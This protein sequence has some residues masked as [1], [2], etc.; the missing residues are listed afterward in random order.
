MF[1]GKGA[2]E[3][4]DDFRRIKALPIRKG[5]PEGLVDFMSKLLRVPGS[6]ATLREVQARALYELAMTK[7]AFLPIRIGGGKSLV[8]LLAA[9]VLE[10]KRPLLIVPAKLVEKTERERKSYGKDW[11]V[12]K[13]LKI[14]SYELLGRVSGA[15]MIALYNPD[16]IIVDECFAAGTGI[17]TETGIRPI[18]SIRPGDRVWCLSS[19]GWLLRDVL[20]TYESESRDIYH[21][22]IDTRVYTCTGGHPFCT[23]RGWVNARDLQEGDAILSDMRTGFPDICMQKAGVLQ[24]KMQVYPGVSSATVPNNVSD[25]SRSIPANEWDDL[26]RDKSKGVGRSE[27][28]GSS[29]AN[30]RGQWP[31]TLRA[32]T[33]LIRSIGRRLGDRITLSLGRLRNTGLDRGHS[34]PG[35]ENSGGSRRALARQFECAKQGFEKERLF[36]RA[37]LGCVTSIKRDADSRCRSVYN[38]H[39]R[40]EENYVLSGGT[41]V[42]NCHKLKNLKAACTRRVARFMREHPGTTFVAMSGTIMK[43]SVKDFAH[44]IEWSHGDSSPLPLYTQTLLE[45]S[46]ALDEDTNMFAR[47]EGGVLHDL[48]P[49]PHADAREAFYDRCSSTYGVTISDVKDDFQGSLYIEGI[50]YEPNAA[51]EANFQTLRETM[52]KPNGYA[53]SD[54]MQGWAVARQLAL[55]FH[56][57]F[58]PAPPQEYLDARKAWAK[59]CRDTIDSPW[60]SRNQIDTELQVRTAVMS[61]KIDDSLGLWPTWQHWDHTTKLNTIGV[62]HDETALNLAA[63]WLEKHDRGIVWCEHTFFG[64]ELSR[65]TGLPYFKEQGLAIDGSG[66][67]IEDASGPIIASVAANFEGRNLQRNWSDNLITACPADSERIDQLVGRTHRS[68]QP[69]DTVTVDVLIGCREHLEAIPRA[70]A[71]AKVKRDL[72]GFDLKISLA[73]VSWPDTYKPRSGFRWA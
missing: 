5:Y 17:R 62:W 7:K 48:M 28:Y 46:E 69:E 37:G 20:D 8:S 12:A 36:A 55:G 71:S 19:N 18:E 52:C 24:P 39:V 31:G 56:Y 6:T 32:A 43:R 26:P 29:A 60:A 14:A 16:L 1:T 49:T 21:V 35:A 67:F 61:G 59:F 2:V 65:R 68:G 9:R 13:H 15:N 72:L 44:I 63:K 66:A 10:A 27:G 58:D 53:L 41:V 11:N 64:R 70:L 38:L 73:D 30:T 57:E 34:E 50:E 42:H 51:T 4:S 40:G 23:D 47:R 3:D 54:A 22:Q 25:Q 45:W 33:T